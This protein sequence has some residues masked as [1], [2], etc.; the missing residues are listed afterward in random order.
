MSISYFVELKQEVADNRA[1]LAELS[2]DF[3]TSKLSPDALKTFSEWQGSVETLDQKERKA[4]W[5]AKPKVQKRLREAQ[6]N[7]IWAYKAD[8]ADWDG[9]AFRAQAEIDDFR[10]RVA[11]E[12][13]EAE[14]KEAERL[15]FNA[16]HKVKQ[17]RIWADGKTID[18]PGK[19]TWAWYAKIW[20]YGEDPDVDE[21]EIF[22]E[23]SGF[24]REATN[25]QAE[26]MAL[27]QALRWASGLND[28]LEVEIFSDSDYAIG[29]ILSFMKKEHDCKNRAWLWRASQNA[30]QVKNLRGISWLSRDSAEIAHAHN[31]AEKEMNKSY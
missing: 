11:A 19:S 1:A 30:K 12:K 15:A 22:I 27:S 18:N 21:A 17:V 23:K 31:L 24:M 3:D 5:K 13:E 14:A 20:E 26:I 10:H 8:K 6:K 7:L 9:L 25:N 16:K 29:S 4:F 2:K 28:K